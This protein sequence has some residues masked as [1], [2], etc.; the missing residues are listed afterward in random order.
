[1]K[2]VV[3]DGGQANSMAQSSTTHPEITHLYKL[4]LSAGKAVISAVLT[5]ASAASDVFHTT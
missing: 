4:K 5:A 1:M 2:R 3:V